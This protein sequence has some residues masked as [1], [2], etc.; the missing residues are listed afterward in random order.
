MTVRVTALGGGRGLA[1]TLR[2]LRRVDTVDLAITAI[3]S[4]ADDGGSTGRLRAE[5]GIPAPGDVRKCLVALGEDD[6]WAAA[7][8]HRFGAGSLRGHSLGNLVLAGLSEHLGSFG[9]AVE[10]MAT[11]LRAR[12]RV[13]PAALDPVT[14]VAVLADGREVRGQVAVQEAE[15]RIRSVRLEPSPCAPPEAV[16]AVTAADLVLLA[17]GS[18]YTSLL[19]VLA[20]GGIADAVRVGGAP[21]VQLGNLAVQIPETAGLGV[22]DHVRAVVDHG[23][24]VDLYLHPADSTVPL[25]AAALPT[26]VQ[27]RRHDALGSGDARTHDVGR[28]AAALAALLASS[29][30][31]R[32]PRS[33]GDRAGERGG[34]R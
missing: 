27:L 14:L 4:V 31:R 18:L 24:R 17:P 16:A 20:S 32:G 30:R 19:P 1:T 11:L 23:G 8:E 12:G 26:T 28:L 6:A 34:K 9:A 3:V 29:S 5:L 13:L 7:C 10:T 21:V 22:A 25:D 33:G 15:G 2:A